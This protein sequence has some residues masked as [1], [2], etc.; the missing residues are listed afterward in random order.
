MARTILRLEQVADRTGIPLGTLR[1]WRSRNLGEGPRTWKMGRRVVAYED[2]V[3][4]WVDR[5]SA[6]ATRPT[7]VPA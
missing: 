7:G 5:Q 4:A 1:Y 3:N 2:D 6:R